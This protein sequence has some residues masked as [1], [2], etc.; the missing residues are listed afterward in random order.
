MCIRDRLIIMQ[1]DKV[2]KISSLA[3][4]GVATPIVE[5]AVAGVESSEPGDEIDMGIF[6]IGGIDDDTE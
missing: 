2:T 6:V 4:G 3:D 5:P 1:M